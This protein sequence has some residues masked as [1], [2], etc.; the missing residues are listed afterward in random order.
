MAKIQLS[1]REYDLL[2]SNFHCSHKKGYVWWNKICDRIDEVHTTK[3]LETNPNFHHK[4]INLSYSL[5]REKMTKLE[6]A[7]A[8]KMKTRFRTFSKGTRLDV[9]QFFKDWDRLGTD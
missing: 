1:D 8:E 9:K 5:S 4:K 3:M 7:I 6:I 2:V